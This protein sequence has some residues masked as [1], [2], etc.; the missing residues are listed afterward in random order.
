MMKHN[1]VKIPLLTLALLLLAAPMAYPRDGVKFSNGRYQLQA[2]NSRVAPGLGLTVTALYYYGD[3]DMLGIAFKEGFQ[4]HNLTAGG[5]INFAYMMPAWNSANWR[6]TLAGGWIHGNDKTRS[7]TYHKGFFETYFG[8]LDAGIEWYPFRQAGFYI[9]AGLGANLNSAKYDFT[10][11]NR[12]KGQMFSF[13][14]MVVGEIGWNFAVKGAWYLGI[15]ASIHN[16]LVDINHM[17]LDGWYSGSQT[18]RPD[19]YFTIGLTLSWRQGKGK[20]L[21]PCRFL[22]N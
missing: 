11:A 16:G 15:N 10:R 18:G 20:S 1:S 7:G 8:E 21:C 5:Q 6:F 9:Y 19:G 14:P 17:N 13:L 2:R 3:V 12:G 4:K 22:N